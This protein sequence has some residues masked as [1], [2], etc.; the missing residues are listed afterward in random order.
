MLMMMCRT[1]IRGWL[2]KAGLF[3]RR[4][5]MDDVCMAANALRGLM[6]E[7]PLAWRVATAIGVPA[8]NSMEK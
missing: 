4:Q 6:P 2:D 1:C 7:Q 3:L 8:G 5:R